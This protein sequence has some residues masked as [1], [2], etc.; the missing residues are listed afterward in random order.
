M[1]A[2]FAV[3]HE[4]TPREGEPEPQAGTAGRKPPPPVGV[5]ADLL[6]YGEPNPPPPALM[7]KRFSIWIWVLLALALGGFIALLMVMLSS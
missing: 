6:D 5:T 3:P 4:F 2:S 1:L 7:R